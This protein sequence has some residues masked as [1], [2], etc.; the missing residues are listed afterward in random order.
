MA[1]ESKVSKVTNLV[2]TVKDGDTTIVSLS[3]SIYSDTGVAS[4]YSESITNS[5]LYYTNLEAVR[6]EVD[7]F[8]T[9]MRKIED[10]TVAVNAEPAEE[11]VT[12]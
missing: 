10:E 8:R 6:V 4:S 2:G 7:A 11:P 3:A 5:N 1:I 9:E 12:T